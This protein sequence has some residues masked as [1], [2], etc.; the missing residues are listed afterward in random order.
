MFKLRTLTVFILVALLTTPI[1]AKKVKTAEHKD[2]VLTDLRLNYTME[3]PKNWKVKTFKEKNEAPELLR[4]LLIQKNYMVNPDAD[5]FDGE[6]T[7]PEVQ[8][9]A[10]ETDMTKEAFLDSLK[11]AVEVHNTQIDL[12]DKLNLLLSGEY[13]AVQEVTLSGEDCTLA[14]FKRKWDRTLVGDPSDP[15]LRAYGGRI[16]QSIHD[17]HEIYIFKHNDWLYVIQG[18]AEAEF[19]SRVEQ[20]IKKIVTSLQFGDMPVA[21]SAE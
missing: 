10:W 8:V 12:I 19:Y 9:Y 20:E 3:I 15:R 7:I 6:Y 2:G 5:A 17:V 21:E 1:F 4:T 14:F 13:V 16:V 18:I 11:S